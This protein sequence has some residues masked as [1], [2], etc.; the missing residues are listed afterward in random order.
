[1][2]SDMTSNFRIG[3]SGFHYE[4]WKGRFYPEGVKPKD[5]LKF[6]TR[7]FDT[8]ELNNT[9][10]QLPRSTSID[11]WLSCVGPGFTFTIK[12]SRYITHLKRLNEPHDSLKM[13][14]DR[15]ELFG[16]KVGPILWQ[17]PP[18]FP[19]DPDRLRAFLKLLPRDYDH[20]FEFRDPTWFTPIVYSLL[21]KRKAAFCIYDRGDFLSPHIITSDLV[22]IRLHG[23][24]EMYQGK[25]PQ[26]KLRHWSQLMEQ[27]SHTARAVFAYF[28]NDQ[29]AFA[30]E[31]ALT[32][33]KLLHQPVPAAL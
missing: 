20:V 18:R 5:F 3:T 8:V 27:W 15:I 28:N 25:Y 33:K 16:D 24:Q 19:A 32:L 13:F 21:E 9:F 22:Y 1:M 7:F 10:Y 4:H 11:H 17:L 29:S 14:F 6:Y 26:N 2:R 31:N 12:G 30:V 23:P